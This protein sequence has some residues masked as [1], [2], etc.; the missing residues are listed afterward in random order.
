MNSTESAHGGPEG[1]ESG[2]WAGAPESAGAGAP[3]ADAVEQEAVRVW[4]GMRTLVLETA[5][6]RPRVV[7]ALGM[8]YFRAKALRYVA[9]EGPLTLSALA[10]ALFADAPYTTLSVDYLVQRGLVTREPNPADRR[11]K[12]VEVTGAGAAAAAEMA[13][14]TDTPPPALRGLAAADLAAL[15]RIL[16]RALHT[17]PAD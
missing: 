6:V 15:A 4:R 8:S 3:G 10:A 12:L 1:T 16:D 2:T 17:G 5:D 14:I 11:S 13:R 7:E 9:D